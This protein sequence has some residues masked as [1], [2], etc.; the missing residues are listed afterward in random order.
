MSKSPYRL[1][2]NENPLGSS[3]KVIQRIKECLTG[4]SFYPHRDDEFLRD[5]LALFYGDGLTKDHFFSTYS[6]SEALDLIARVYLQSGDEIIVCEPTFHVYSRTA[7]WQNAVVTNV[8][9]NSDDF[10][11]KTNAV[12]EAV[13]SRTKLIYLGNPNNPTGTIVTKSE[14]AT[15]YD[16]L[17]QDVVIVS[18]EVYHHFVASPDYP[19]SIRDIVKGK[20]IIVL[21]SFS[22]AYG[23]AGLRMGVVIARPEI[24]ERLVQLRRTFH[25]G[26]LEME[27]AT[28]A[29]QDQF[30]VEKTV[31]LA[32]EGKKRLY[33]EFDR[34][35]IK[36]WRS[37]GNFVLFQTP[38]LADDLASQMAE[39]GIWV[40]SGSRFGLNYSIR[41]SIGLPEA[42][43]KFVASLEKIL[44]GSCL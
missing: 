26:V 7:E 23:L 29:L 27:A 13:T 3:P 15:L 4:I 20:N 9:L 22:K 30:H 16:S 8:P 34:L 35:I 10:S 32:M 44:S 33:G 6:G 14:M 28:V 37:E 43:E 1:H 40:G 11:L 19:N 38:M 36:Y 17:P 21:H 41:V 12:Q 31:A 2:Y 25:L 39:Y 42:N 5:Q 18:D 24:I